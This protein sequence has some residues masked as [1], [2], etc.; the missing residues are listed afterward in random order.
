MDLDEKATAFL[1][2]N[3][4]AAMVTLRRDG[5]PHVARIAVCL[6]DSRILSS[7]TQTRVRTRNLR[8]DPRCTLF[9]FELPSQPGARTGGGYL[10][11]ETTV[12]IHNGPDAGQR[13][14]DYM[15]FLMGTQDGKVVYQGQPRTDEEF[16]DL[17]VKEQRILYEFTPTRAYGVY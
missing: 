11:L 10:G 5:M 9:V 16:L 8:R 13:N 17:M 1:Q 14:L 2:A 4:G 7:S 6:I 12:R 3:R 15:R